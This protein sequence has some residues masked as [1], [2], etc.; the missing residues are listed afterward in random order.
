[1]RAAV[2]DARLRIVGSGGWERFKPRLEQYP[3]VEVIGA[4][5]DL[6]SEYERARFSVIPVFEGAG[7]KIK[8]LESL[9][10]GRTVAAHS[11][12]IRGF[13]ELTHMQSLLEGDS[14]EG[15]AQACI[16]LFQDA[17]LAHRLAANGARIVAQS[18]SFAEFARTVAADVD[19][20]LARVACED[21]RRTLAQPQREDAS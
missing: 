19:A 17:D 1:V 8:V 15:I 12:A 21:V 7:T 20:V 14:H 18:Y 4:V 6:A 13:D 9:R 11:H 2:P 10:H 16:A 3:G 5:D